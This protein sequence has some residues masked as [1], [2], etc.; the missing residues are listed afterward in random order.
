MRIEAQRWPATGRGAIGNTNVYV[1]DTG[2]DGSHPDLSV[3]ES[4]SFAKGGGRN[5]DCNGHGTHVAGTIAAK[6]DTQG[7]VGVAPGAA[8]H[9]VKVLNCQ[10][11]GS[12]SWTSSAASTGLP[13]TTAPTRS[14]T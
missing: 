5:G 11:A 8:I 14:R 12:W 3:V 13:R 7:V 9:A 1:I 6:D 10:V 4:V 2:V